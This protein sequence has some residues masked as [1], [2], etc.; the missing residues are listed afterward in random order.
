MHLQILKTL[1]PVKL[2]QRVDQQGHDMSSVSFGQRS[3]RVENRD[4]KKTIDFCI[5]GQL[6]IHAVC[7]IRDVLRLGWGSRQRTG[8]GWN[9]SQID[10]I[11]TNNQENI[12]FASFAHLFQWTL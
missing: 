10:L 11:R 5:V 12:C 2:G 6:G 4:S 9:K 8:F 3:L 1:S 7:S